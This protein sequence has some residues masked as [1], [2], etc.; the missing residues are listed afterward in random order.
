MYLHL[1]ILM[2]YVARHNVMTVHHQSETRFLDGRIVRL[3]LRLM[4]KI[5]VASANTD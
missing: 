5:I 3:S 4:G 2:Q 1:D